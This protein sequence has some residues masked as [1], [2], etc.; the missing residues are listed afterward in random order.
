MKDKRLNI[1]AISNKNLLLYSILIVIFIYCLIGIFPITRFETDSVAIANACEEMIQSGKLEENVLGHSYHMQSGTY[2]LIVTLSKT[3]GLSAFSSYSLLTIFFAFI[4]WIFLF[5]L[6]KKITNVN[7]FLIII[8]LFLFQEIFILSYYANSTVISSAFWVFAFYL[9]WINN[10]NISLIISALLL[11]FAAWFRVDI[12][13]VFPSVLLLLY[14]KNKNIKSAF[15]KSIVLAV[16]V[17]LVTLLLM[18]LMNANVGGFLGYTEYHGELFSTGHNIGLLDLHVVKAHAAY[19]SLLLL[20]LIGVSILILL[21][22]KQLIPVL[23]LISG[24]LFYYLLGINNTVAPKHLSYFT[25]FWALIILFALNYY[26]DFRPFARKILVTAALLLFV[27]QYIIGFRVNI[28]SI[29]YQFDENAVLKPEPTIISLGSFVLNKPS[30]ERINFVI[31]AG[32]KIST[33]DE[34][35][36]SSGLLFSPVMWYKQK[37]GLFD[38]FNKLTGIINYSVRD[39]LSILVTDGSTGFVINNLLTNGYKWKEKKIDFSSEVHQLTFQKPG[40]PIMI[41]TRYNLNKTNFEEFI[42]GYQYVKITDCYFVFIWDWQNYYI[43]KLDLP[44]I[45]NVTYQ[46]HKLK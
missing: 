28:N 24:I 7:P 30:I 21:I 33:A 36:A 6:L 17:I 25:L 12:A 31:G 43:Q 4:Y 14:M 10:D 38:S 40:S 46:I 16:I 22:K 45:E 41:V 23:F 42:S 34:L 13:F 1:R 20:F 8:L 18:H 32:T 44:F 29:P 15:L 27:S 11:S 39:T 9:L 2:F 19:F 37:E 3:F 5:L 26:N 35:S